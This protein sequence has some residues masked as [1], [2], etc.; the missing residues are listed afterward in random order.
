M[1]F[2]PKTPLFTKLKKLLFVN[3]LTSSNPNLMNIFLF[4]NPNLALQFKKGSLK[5]DYWMLRYLQKMIF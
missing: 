1:D 5:L 4:C 3:N 2:W